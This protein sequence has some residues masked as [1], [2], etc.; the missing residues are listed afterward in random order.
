MSKIP[1]IEETGKKIDKRSIYPTHSGLISLP[2]NIKTAGMSYRNRLLLIWLDE[3]S[4][5]IRDVRIG[6]HSEIFTV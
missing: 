3:S 1:K 5:Y 6:S 4:E 2:A